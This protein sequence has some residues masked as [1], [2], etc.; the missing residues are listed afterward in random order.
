MVGA[1]RIRPVLE[2]YRIRPVLGMYRTRPTLSNYSRHQNHYQGNRGDEAQNEVVK[3]EKFP[4]QRA[5]VSDFVF[6]FDFRVE[7]AEEDGRRQRTYRHQVGG[8]DEV[9]E[10]EDG[11][12]E[13]GPVLD[14]AERQGAENTNDEDADHADDR[15]FAAAPV[16]FFHGEG[17]DDF[18][19]GNGG[20]E[21]GNA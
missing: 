8:G 12:V 2:T 21:R 18:L 9:E 17:H 13:K 6:D 15:A 19:Q 5:A 16:E 10:V 7:P 3:L 20:G 4:F 11:A 1:Y 14:G